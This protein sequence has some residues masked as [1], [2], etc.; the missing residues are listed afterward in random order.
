MAT[1]ERR[2]KKWRVAVCVKRVRRSASF[3]SKAAAA[4]WALEQE[5]QLAA[6]NEA[7][8]GATVRNLLGRY[9]VEVAPKKRGARWESLRL[10]RIGEGKLGKVRLAELR[11]AD[12]ATWRDGRLREV[13]PATV[14]REWNLL[15]HAFAIARTEWHWLG[16]D[17]MT[18]VERPEPP[19]G[20]ERRVTEAEVAALCA[21]LG[22]APERPPETASARVAMAFMLA[23]ETG[24]RAGELAGLTW[25]RLDL[26][27][28]VAYLPLTKNGTARAVP[29]STAAVRLFEQLP[30]REGPALCLST[31]Q[32][33]ALFRKGKKKAGLADLHFHD[34]RHE[35]VCRLSKKLDVLDL[36]RVIGHRDLRMLMRYYHASAAELAGRLD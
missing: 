10:A 17:P 18:G 25:G 11:A 20:R 36:A 5:T 27:E 32:I 7:P 3:H 14:R 9:A 29:L 4:A 35:A 16:A 26:V 12:I 21:A 6:G 13:S 2:G 31:S 1:I 23:I 30:G 19:Q 34:S 28:R 33:D 8:P 15:H 22:Y 24:M